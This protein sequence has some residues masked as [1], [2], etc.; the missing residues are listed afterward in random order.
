M[1]LSD[2]KSE[3]G[4]VV[5]MLFDTPPLVPEPEEP[6]DDEDDDVDDPDEPIDPDN[7][8]APLG[9]PPDDDE[10]TP[11]ELPIG[12]GIQVSAMPIAL[13]GGVFGTLKL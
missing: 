9:P 12:I 13:G 4:S 5:G 10:P 11:S 3:L 6:E 1:P 8:P 7:D 2:A